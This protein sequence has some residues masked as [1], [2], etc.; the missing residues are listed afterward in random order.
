M[1]R[2][3]GLFGKE[4]SV[5]G[6]SLI[7]MITLALSNLLGLFRDRFLTKNISTFD[8]DIYYAAFRIPDLVFN[9]LILGA[10]TAA[11]IPVFSEFITNKDEEGGY[12]VTNSLINLAA[13]AMIVM[14]IILYFLMPS[15]M[16]LVV[17]KFDSV[18]MSQS[19]FYARL[20]M[21]TPIF[22][23][24]SYI[25]G[26]VLNSHKRF[27][28]YA[29]A[30][31]IYNASIIFGAAYLAPRYG[32]T[33][34]IYT[35]I[36]GAFLHM[37]I[38]IPS[39]IRLGFS[40]KLVF[41]WG[42]ESIKKIIRLMIPRTIGM[43]MGQLMLVVY[44]AIASALTVGSI[45]ALNLSN[46]IQT[47]PSVVFGTSFATAVFP[48][49]TAKIATSDSKGFA[50]YLNRS[51]RSIAYLLIPSTVVFIIFRAQII[52][53]IL[54]SG[55]FDWEDT[56]RTALTLGF[57]SLSLLFQGLIPLLARAFY[58]LKNTKTP[59][60][61]S[62]VSTTI[63]IALAYPLA[64]R[65]GVAGLALSFSIGSF[66]NA[67][68]LYYFLNKKYASYLNKGLF[69]SLLKITLISLVMG[70]ALYFTAHFMALRV[71]MNRFHGVLTQTLVSLAVGG[72]VYFGL[73]YW[74]DCDEMKWALTRKINGQNNEPNKE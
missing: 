72:I 37:L 50:F 60:Y 15:L 7:L 74:F 2:I 40:Y 65:M 46:N 62:I 34:V 9:F 41:D 54:G 44:T 17:P 56:K 48:T 49:L 28:A 14:A 68:I 47:M 13:L 1:K 27:L 61:I 57:F 36:A 22:F 24:I 69:I 58:A 30:P 55:K 64:Q 66:L 11:F 45:A 25:I 16:P 32:L 52:R 70:V 29:F 6:A 20:L 42:S 63:S 23:A 26:G 18:R 38:Q 31:L 35:V 12:R 4:N 71:D 21:I 39:A 73:S 43:G 3:F 10:I 5:R 33:S 67:I 51:M 19:I 59:M 53:L 8:L